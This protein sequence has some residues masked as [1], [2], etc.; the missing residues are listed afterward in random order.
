MGSWD[1]TQREQLPRLLLLDPQYVNLN[2]SHVV[3]AHLCTMP[4]AA[5]ASIPMDTLGSGIPKSLSGVAMPRP[6]ADA[7]TTAYSSDSPELLAIV[8]WVLLYVCMR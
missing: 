2:V 5:L 7:R 1:F 6:S 3:E 4:I 8:L